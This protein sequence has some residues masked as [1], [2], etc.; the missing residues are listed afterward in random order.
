MGHVDKG[1]S[2]H[3]FLISNFK[4]CGLFV[5]TQPLATRSETNI[6]LGDKRLILDK[7][8]VYCYDLPYQVPYTPD[9]SPKARLLV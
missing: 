7:Q 1:R 6:D 3:G 8:N 9:L 2:E 5:L 4:A